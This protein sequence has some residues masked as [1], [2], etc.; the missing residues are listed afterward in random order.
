MEKLLIKDT[1]AI[2]R[3]LKDDPKK[4]H[5]RRLINEKG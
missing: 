2:K 3:C 4:N 5:K 1:Y